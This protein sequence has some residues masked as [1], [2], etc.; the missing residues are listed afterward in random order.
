M[1]RGMKLFI[2][3]FFAILL[4]IVS[5]CGKIKVFYDYEDNKKSG[6]IFIGNFSI[7]LT[8]GASVCSAI[9]AYLCLN[10]LTPE[11]QLK[12]YESAKGEIAKHKI[13]ETEKN[14]TE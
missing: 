11:E 4:Q 13:F 14:T 3:L 8:A 5:L 12:A 1:Y 7:W 10:K 6:R 9:G 2:P